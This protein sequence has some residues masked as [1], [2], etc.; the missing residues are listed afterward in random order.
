MHSFFNVLQACL[1]MLQVNMTLGPTS[2]NFVTLYTH[3]PTVY[4]QYT[5]Y[6][7][8]INSIQVSNIRFGTSLFITDG[9]Q[10]L[11]ITA[12]L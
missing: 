2:G 9:D 5:V 11:G 7:L 3:T 1:Q 12:S 10:Q 6:I 4:I 8:Y